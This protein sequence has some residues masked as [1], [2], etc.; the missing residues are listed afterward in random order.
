[1]IEIGQI[2]VR[3]NDDR[4]QSKVVGK[5]EFEGIQHYYLKELSQNPHARMNLLSTVT[6]KQLLLIFTFWLKLSPR[7]LLT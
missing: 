3:K 1:M 7:C 6:T 2:L 5:C 4:I